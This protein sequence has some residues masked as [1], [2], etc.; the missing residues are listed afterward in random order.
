MEVELDDVRSAPELVCDLR[1]HRISDPA[2]LANGAEALQLDEQ[3]AFHSRILVA[4][5]QHTREYL[6]VEIF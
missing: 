6:S 5:L 3:H 1:T 2:E 4:R